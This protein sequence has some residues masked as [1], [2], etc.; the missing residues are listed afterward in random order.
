[1]QRTKEIINQRMLER[2]IIPITNH[3]CQ[4]EDELS[5]L[6][7]LR[8]LVDNV[9]QAEEVVSIA[10]AGYRQGLR[11]MD[12]EA[13]QRLLRLLGIRLTG[14]GRTVLVTGIIDPSLFTT[15][16]TLA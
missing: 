14:R 4:L 11:E 16:Q 13:R 8:S 5:L 1:M 12:S 10:L 15:G 7:A 6:L 3:L 2:L 9:D